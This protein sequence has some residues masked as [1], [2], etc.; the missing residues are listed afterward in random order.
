M[1]NINTNSLKL[2]KQGEVYYFTFP[3]FEKYDFLSHGFSTRLGGVSCGIYE[4]MNLGF[5]RGDDYSNVFENYKIFSKALGVDYKNLVFGSQVHGDVIRDVTEMD[6][7]KGIIKEKEYS[8]VDG[9]ITNVPGIP[10]V[11]LFADCVPIFYFDPVKKIIG[12]AHSGWRGTV[13][14]IG[15]K[16][17]KKFMEYGSSKED[18]LVGIGPSIGPCCF[19]VGEET[20]EEFRSL[21]INI[22]NYLEKD[23][24]DKYKI[25]LWEINRKILIDSGIKRE[26]ITV[27]DI[28]TMC[29]KDLLFSHR[30]SNG[31]RGS[32]AGIIGLR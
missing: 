29:S 18:I 16:M 19:Q 4:S 20:V 15:E 27:T 1:I 8:D 25:N 17:V 7:G 10:L 13:L 23:V 2:N 31:K 5:N 14:K 28:C 22:E 3:S 30:G 26:N 24:K 32:L 6:K 12:I 11:G 9:L 21:H